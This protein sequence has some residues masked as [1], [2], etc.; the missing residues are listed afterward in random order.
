MTRWLALIPAAIVALG[1]AIAW[2]QLVQQNEDQDRRIHKIEDAVI[3]MGE[4]SARQERID[5]RTLHIQQ[6]LQEQRR[7]LDGLVRAWGVTPP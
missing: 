3:N 4:L 2:G 5:E 6:N 1:A 7:L